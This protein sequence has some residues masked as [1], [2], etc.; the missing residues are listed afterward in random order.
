MLIIE[1]PD[2]MLRDLTNSKG[3]TELSALSMESLVSCENRNVL[4]LEFSLCMSECL[5]KE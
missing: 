2:K 3:G 1:Q 5:A 4:N